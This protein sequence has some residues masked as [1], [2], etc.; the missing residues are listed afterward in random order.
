M[1]DRE[2]GEGGEGWNGELWTVFSANH[3]ISE[4][5]QAMVFGAGRGGA[6]RDLEGAQ[7][8]CLWRPFP[9]SEPSGSFQSSRKGALHLAFCE[10]PGCPYAAPGQEHQA[11]P[12]SASKNSPALNL[13]RSRCSRH[14]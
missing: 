1:E 2:L 9:T 11:A 8:P 7:A 5:G 12:P 6:R 4:N 13:A 14:V 10:S 3:G